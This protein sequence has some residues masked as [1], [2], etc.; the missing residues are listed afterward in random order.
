MKLTAK[1]QLIF[2]AIES[3]TDNFMILGKP[4]VGKSVLINALVDRGKKNYS[5][6]APTGLAAINIGGKTLHSLFKIPV[7][8]NG[9]IPLNVN[10]PEKRD[11]LG[12]HHVHHLIIDEVSM[13]RA[14]LL[15]YIDRVMKHFRGNDSPFG[16][17]QVIMVGDFCQ[18]P[19]VCRAEDRKEL[20]A[21][22]YQSEF[23]FSAHSF[24]LEMFKIFE[25]TEVLRQKDDLY[26]MEILNAARFGTLTNSMI[27]DLNALVGSPKELTITL[28]ATNKQ[29][30]EINSNEMRRINQEEAFYAAEVSGEWPEALWP[31]PGSIRL[32][33]TAQVMVRKNGADRDPARPEDKEYALVNGTLGVI[34]EIERDRLYIKTDHGT[35]PVYRQDFSRTRKEEQEDGT[36]KNKV[37]ANFNQMPLLPAWAISMH[38]SQGQS[39]DRVNI[40]P[41]KVFA[42]GQLYVALSRARTMAGMTLLSS[43]DSRKFAINRIVKS[44]YEAL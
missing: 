13:L 17:I 9:I 6:A 28:T 41:S 19:P 27:K 12:L 20:V 35:H 36:W 34:E 39:F 25:L 7:F 5:I 38:K 32:K 24:E 8:E 40:D 23:A 11:L 26:F 43:V 29:A 16:G 22:G 33:P 37:Y 44:F 18:L 4:G 3:S 31:L 10:L 30:D 21:A 1:Q 2:D 42:P 15:D 14:D